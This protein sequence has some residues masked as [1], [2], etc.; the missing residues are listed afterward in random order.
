MQM[1]VCDVIGIMEPVQSSSWFDLSCVSV[2]RS[3]VPSGEGGKEES[4]GPVQKPAAPRKM[5]GETL[6]PQ[7]RQWSPRVTSSKV[8]VVLLELSMGPTL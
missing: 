7:N 1:P 5:T 4:R 8:P 6:L 2:Q 3:G